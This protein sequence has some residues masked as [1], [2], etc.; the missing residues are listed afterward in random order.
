MRGRQAVRWGVVGATSLTAN[1]HA[2][3]LELFLDLVFV[4]SVTQITSFVAVDLSPAGVAKGA[5]LGFLVWWQ[6]TA[7]TWTGTAIDFQSDARARLIVL[8]MVPAM[9][10]MAVSVPAA[11]DDQGVWFAVAYLIVQL[12]VLGLQGV[13]SWQLARTRRAW[14]RYAPLAAIAPTLLVVGS[15]LNGQ[16][17]IAV[18][19]AVVVLLIMSALLAADTG[20][21]TGEW[22]IDPTHFAERHSLFVIITLGEVLVAVGATAT[23]ASSERGLD[24]STLFALTVAAGVACALW[25]VYF[26]YVPSVIEHNLEHEAPHERGRVARDVGSFSHFPLVFGVICYAVVAKHLVAHPDGHLDVADRWLLFLSV[27]LFVGALLLMQYRLVRR[28]APER[29]VA[30]AAVAAVAASAGVVP[31]IAVLAIVAAVLTAMALISWR[32]FQA[33]QQVPAAEWPN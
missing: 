23:A 13:E 33:A 15:V 25:W 24:A 19:V 26:G 2:S 17:R 8:G 18:W 32:R 28:L 30:I 1:R 16:G 5:L 3:N 20:S 6:W 7:F 29:I 11:L 14:F 27:A 12:F 31:G 9:L 4:F 10:V 22:I 21:G